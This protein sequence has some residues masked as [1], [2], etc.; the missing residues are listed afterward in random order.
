MPR[1]RYQRPTWVKLVANICVD[2]P[3]GDIQN[4]RIPAK[5]D[6]AFILTSG[7]DGNLIEQSLKHS[8]GDVE[9][10]GGQLRDFYL[11]AEGAA[12]VGLLYQQV[13][14]QREQLSCNK[15]EL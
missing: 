2:N 14:D 7:F 1:V 3:P 12:Q 9:I 4:D 6:K 15:D 11:A 10:I 5:V 13:W 8:L